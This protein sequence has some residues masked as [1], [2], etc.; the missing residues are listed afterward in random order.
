MEEKIKQ[1]LEN[2]FSFLKDS[3]TIKR[4]GRLF[5]EVSQEHFR[6]VFDY[7]VKNLGFNAL[8]AIT[9]LDLEDK[10]AVIYHI[11]KN[12]NILFNLKTI[13]NKGSKIQTVTDVF[14]SADIYE[15]EMIDLFGI[16]VEGLKPG[17]TYPL[18]DGWPKD[19]H[20]LLKSWTPQDKEREKNA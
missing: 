5:A 19:Q 2:K 14:L 4:K 11:N 17:H 7:S 10:F 16:K 18:P 8:S 3:V 20:P 6:Q 9:G 15:R 1:D 13:F 12:G